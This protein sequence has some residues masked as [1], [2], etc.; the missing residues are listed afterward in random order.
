VPRLALPFCKTVNQLFGAWAEFSLHQPV[1]LGA[2]VV[3]RQT[4]HPASAT[5]G[6]PVEVPQLEQ[7]APLD[8]RLRAKAG[9]DG[10]GGAFGGGAVGGAGV[11]QIAHRVTG[12]RRGQ[13]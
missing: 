1:G 2:L 5:D 12:W 3:Q 7:P 13:I 10:I 6:Q 8:D 4:Q 11:E 9:A